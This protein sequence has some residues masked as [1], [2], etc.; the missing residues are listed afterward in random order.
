MSQEW[1]RNQYAGE[2]PNPKPA[3]AIAAVLL[4]VVSVAAICAYRYAYVLTP[5]QKFYFK[6]YIRSE[7]RAEI[8]LRTGRYT[9]LNVADRNGS[10]LVLD[11][12]V[13]PVTTAKDETR[14]AL[15]EEAMKLG[16]RRLEWQQ[17][18]YDN[19]TFHAFLGHWIY[20]DQTFVD[21]L[22]PALFGGLAVFFL[23]LLVAIPKDAA[24]AR[25]RKEGRRLKG[26]ELVTVSDFNRRNRSDGIG[27]EEKQT[28][29]QKV[30]GQVPT[31]RLPR[32]IEPSHILIMGDTGTGKST[33]IRRI[34]LQI[35][36]RNETAIVYDPALDYTP[37]FYNPERG[38]AILNPLD[39]RMPY[40]SPGDELRHDA[41]ALTLAASL[42]PDR[43][44]ENPFFVEGPRKIFA[45]LLTFRPTPEEMAWWMCHEEQIDRRVKGTEYAAL[46]DRQAPAQRSGV[47]ASLNM[48][49]DTLKLLPS[50]KETTAQWNA[51]EWS[52]Q[53][54]GWLF[55]TSTPET[56]K[57]LI[58][59]T[60]L[61]LDTLVLRLM[62]Q[63]QTNPRKVWFVLDELA[64]L[65]RLPQLHTAITENRKSNNPVVLGFQG[66]SQL[67]TRYGHEAEAM[68]SQPATKIFLRTSECRAAEWISKTI[69]EVEIERLR[70]SRSSGQLGRH[71]NTKSYNLERQVE[72][73]V[74][75]SEISGLVDLHG[76][77]KKG[78]VVVRMN[79]PFIELPAKQPKYIERPF[80]KWAETPPKVAAAAIGTAETNEQKLAPQEIAKAQEHHLG[81]TVS[82]QTQEH[83]FE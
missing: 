47:L 27:F 83:F 16:D 24:R 39:A 82:V 29:L 31:L 5:L 15:T 69:G 51:A 1:G 65:Q 64:S 30:F 35:E 32:A 52:K 62:N 78:N 41:E 13:I 68:L 40:W 9:L 42:F 59:L 61:W 28:L 50:E 53:R 46:I 2:W 48:I 60:S 43:H 17:G 4:A 79:F 73:L 21:F 75:A 12:E 63:G 71:R 66:R 36:E 34:L 55:L 18:Q 49:A 54:K 6:T 14:F 44:N 22:K 38:D 10:R 77:L 3:W 72:P 70:E 45:H 56:R 37:E 33:L 80:K 74:M 58:P 26:P 7:L 19:A 67:E 23:G 8:G 25:T 57:R 11:E 81:R 20:R 76:Y